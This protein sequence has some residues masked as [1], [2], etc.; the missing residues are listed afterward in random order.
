MFRGYYGAWELQLYSSSA[1]IY[2]TAGNQTVHI[3]YVFLSVV[4]FLLLLCIDAV[5]C[6]H[7]WQN[8][9]EKMRQV[10]TKVLSN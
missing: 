3:G 6:Y 1:Y 2:D 4:A 5:E 8:I 9:V 7:L 10:C